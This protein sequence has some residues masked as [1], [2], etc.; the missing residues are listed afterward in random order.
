MSIS[1]VE[2][3]KI[4]E[5]IR[6][7]DGLKIQSNVVKDYDSRLCGLALVIEVPFC[8]KN[9]LVPL[10]YVGLYIGTFRPS[11]IFVHHLE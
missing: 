5:I 8:E 4:L 2:N 10:Q 9:Q 6:Q 11:T 3:E 7:K 1:T